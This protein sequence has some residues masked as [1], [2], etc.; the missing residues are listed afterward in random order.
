MHKTNSH[1]VPGTLGVDDADC[2]KRQPIQDLTSNEYKFKVKPTITPNDKDGPLNNTDILGI[3]S[4]SHLNSFFV[5]TFNEPSVS[6]LF[7]FFM[8]FHPFK[9][10]MH[11]RKVL[12]FAI[13]Q[14]KIFSM[15]QN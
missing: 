6:C 10:K 5:N 8:N 12:N 13:K 4:N 15:N 2:T 7:L 3:Q 11:K 9:I 14:T 1:T